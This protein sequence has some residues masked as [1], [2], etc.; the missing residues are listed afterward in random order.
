M[1][2][3]KYN[4]YLADVF[5]E[6]YDAEDDGEGDIQKVVDAVYDR[7][8]LL[9]KIIMEKEEDPESFLNGLGGLDFII[10]DFKYFDSSINRDDA[11]EEFDGIMNDLYDFADYNF[12]WINTMIR[13]LDG[14]GKP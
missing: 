13:S 12:I 7:L 5:N 10:D 4:V 11:I 2:D 3:W 8:T 6:F 14:I 9:R 1:T